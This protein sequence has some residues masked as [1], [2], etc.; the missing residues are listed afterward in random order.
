MTRKAWLLI[1][2]W[3]FGCWAFAAV[4]LDILMTSLSTERTWWLICHLSPLDETC[5][6]Y[7]GFAALITF[8]PLIA[9]GSG[10]LLYFLHRNTD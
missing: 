5:R 1:A 7:W 8:F 2:K 9:L 3:V 10:I 4:P 6:E